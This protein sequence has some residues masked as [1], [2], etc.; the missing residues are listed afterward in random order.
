MARWAR[1]AVIAVTILLA[2]A[3]WVVHTVA[4]GAW[5]GAWDGGPT[6]E[7]VDFCENQPVWLVTLPTAVLL[8]AG[9][10]AAAA[11]GRVWTALI[12]WLVGVAA[13]LTYA[14]V[15]PFSLYDKGF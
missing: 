7:Q 3:A 6:G 13:A 15:V 2:A 9:A 14:V 4:V 12:W 8:L 11:S 1:I 5:C 10:I